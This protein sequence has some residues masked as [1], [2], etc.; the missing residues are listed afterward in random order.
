[1]SA[2]SLD[3]AP[4]PAAPVFV[5]VGQAAPGESNGGCGLCS[6]VQ[7]ATAAAPSYV[8]P[9][10]GVVTRFSV[11]TGS[12]LANPDGEW[13]RARTFRLGDATHAHVISESAQANL[14]TPSATMTFWDRVPAAAGDVLGAQFHTGP[15]IAET[16]NVF[17]T[18]SSGDVAATDITNPGPAVGAD[19]VAAGIASRRVNISARFEHDEDHDGY[20]D[21]SQDLCLGDAAHA[22]SACSGVL[23]GS[24]LQGR[25]QTVGLNCT[26]ACLHLQLTAGGASTSPA[27]DGVVVRWRLQDPPAGTYRVRVLEH[28]SGNSYALTGSSDTVTIPA[29]EALWTFPTRLAIRA[30]GYVA[31]EPPLFTTQTSLVSPPAGSS[32]T[33]LNDSSPA[34]VGSSIPG[35]LAY[36]ADIEPD[37]D[38]DGYGDVTQDGCPASAATHGAC[39]LPFT[40]PPST[41]PPP[42]ATTAASIT[43]FTV[44]YRRFRVQRTGPVASRR[45]HAGT[46][47]R[48]T[49]SAAGT[50]RVTVKRGTKGIRTVHSF[51][52]ALRAGRNAMAYSGRY[53]R[54]G[55]TRTL[56]PG[57]YRI[58]A[59]VVSASG[60]AGPRKSRN[61][62]VAVR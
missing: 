58:D 29:D 35:V 47:L 14:M 19:A 9:F 39:P 5:T 34:S 36:D 52:R 60:I 33:I 41:A 30:G 7:R 15:F 17:T 54:A 11:R 27:A 8:F 20:G 16:P 25:Y 22:T 3:A 38:H 1:M 31:L 6:S 28:V 45:A 53:R 48:I 43:S 2:T 62:T 26:F 37:A 61:V 42:P 21:G 44:R 32:F 59:A 57:T 10:D 24:D 51:D 56:A 46:M 13:M 40:P 49:L 4:A 50:V 12:S 18:A 55:H 23:F